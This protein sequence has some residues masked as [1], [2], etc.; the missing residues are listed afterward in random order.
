MITIINTNTHQKFVDHETSPYTCCVI[1][2]TI[3]ANISIDTQFQI[4][5]SVI[6]SQI[7]I[8][9]IAQTVITNAERIIFGNVVAIIFPHN[10]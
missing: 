10:I 5:F 6:S 4:H 9:H 2:A 1:H 8:S 3:E 7:H